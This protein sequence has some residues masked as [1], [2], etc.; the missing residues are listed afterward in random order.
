MSIIT[1]EG[2]SDVLNLLCLLQFI[3]S[4]DRDSYNPER[5]DEAFWGRPYLSEKDLVSLKRD[6]MECPSP[7]EQVLYQISEPTNEEKSWR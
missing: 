1:D 3:L 7:C 6:G 4:Y 5:W 2:S